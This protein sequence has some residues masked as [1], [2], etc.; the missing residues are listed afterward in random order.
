MVLKNCLEKALPVQ[1]LTDHPKEKCLCC[2]FF[3]TL[4][5]RNITIGISLKAAASCTGWSLW[6][7]HFWMA[8]RQSH[9]SISTSLTPAGILTDNVDTPKRPADTQPRRWDRGSR[10]PALRPRSLGNRGNLGFNAPLSTSR[11]RFLD[12]F[13][14]LHIRPSNRPPCH[15][16]T[17]NNKQRFCAKLSLNANH[18]KT[19]KEATANYLHL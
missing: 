3:F 11:L 6:R 5:K 17:A 2:F 4:F 13:S 1:M 16:Y 12:G 8:E 10:Q 9:T 19:G 15:S 14:F 18:G 7:H